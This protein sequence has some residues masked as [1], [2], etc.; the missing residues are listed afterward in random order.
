MK[1]S[2]LVEHVSKKPIPPHAKHLV[3]EVMVADEE[4]E[5]VEVSCFAYILKKSLS[6][7]SFY[8]LGSFHCCQDLKYRYCIQ[9]L[10]GLS[11]INQIL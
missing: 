5:D 11:E 8:V 7:N 9:R 1:F 6:T 4:D 3:V 2:R 10:H